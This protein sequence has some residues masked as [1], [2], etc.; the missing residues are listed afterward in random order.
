L[1]EEVTRLSIALYAVFA[2]LY[3]LYLGTVADL[4]GGSPFKFHFGD[5]WLFRKIFGDQD[6]KEKEGK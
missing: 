6:S 1:S 3:L 4:H 5:T 2:A